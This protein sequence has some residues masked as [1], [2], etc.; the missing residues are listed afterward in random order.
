MFSVFRFISDLVPEMDYLFGSFLFPL[1][2]W[3]FSTLETSSHIFQQISVPTLT[4]SWQV[5]NLPNISSIKGKLSLA[6]CICHYIIAGKIRYIQANTFDCILILNYK[7]VFCNHKRT[8]IFN[9]FFIY[10]RGG[11]HKGTF[12]L[13]IIDLSVILSTLFYCLPFLFPHG[14]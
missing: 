13:E 5:N 4:L 2:T 14:I 8:R 9:Q 3:S 7:I 1:M 12:P 11:F 6:Y 10:G